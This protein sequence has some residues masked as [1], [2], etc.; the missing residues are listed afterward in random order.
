MNSHLPNR[1]T[2]LVRRGESSIENWW[3]T[4]KRDLILPSH[5]KG[6]IQDPQQVKT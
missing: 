6:A 2:H 3:G 4:L 1:V 5:L